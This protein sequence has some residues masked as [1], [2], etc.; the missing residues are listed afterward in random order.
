LIGSVEPDSEEPHA[1]EPKITAATIET[2][3]KSRRR[4]PGI[5]GT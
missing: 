1:V 4:F 2:A 5:G 3:S